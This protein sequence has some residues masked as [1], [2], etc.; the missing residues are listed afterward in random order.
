MQQAAGTRY[1]HL[2]SPLRLGKLALPDRFA[3][4]PMTTNY[5]ALDGAVTPELCDYMAARGA[6]GFSLI[7]TENVGVHESGRVMPRM[8]MGDE[9]RHIPGLARLADAIRATG[10]R[11]IA[12]ISHCGRQT[13]SKFTGMPLVAPSAIP[14]PVNREMPRALA[15]DEVVEMERAFVATAGR[16]EAAGFDGIEIHAAHGYLAGSFLSAYSNHRTDEYGGSLDNRM[17]FL[18]NIVDGIRRRSDITLTVRISA[19]EFVDQ[20]NTLEQSRVIARALE[21]HGVSAISVSAGVYES[22]AVLSMV[23]GEP[24]GRWLSL[25]RAI[26]GEVRIPVL[27]VGMIKRAAVAEAAVARGDCAIPLFGRAAIADPELPRKIREGREHE[28]LPCVSCNICLGRSGRP[29]TICPVNPA[30]GRDRSFAQ[31][32]AKAPEKALRI[33]V[34][35]SCL[36]ALTAAWIAARRGHQVAVYE[37]DGAIGG[38]QRWRGEVPGQDDYAMLVAAAERRAKQ[39]GVQF[40]FRAPAAGEFDRLWSVRRY[41]PGGTSS[42][43]CYEVLGGDASLPASSTL[44]IQGGDLA[45]AEAAVKLAQSGRQVSLSTPHA[46]IC[47][48]AH[49]GFRVLHRRLIKDLG[50]Q[51]CTSAAPAGAT[52]DATIIAGPSSAPGRSEMPQP[53]WDYPYAASGQG[54]T[55]IDDAYESGRMTAGVYAAVELAIS[56]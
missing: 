14:C 5:A 34:T 35:G 43:N 29:E 15:I 18:L 16:L 20:G 4:A 13:K 6:G 40:L 52:G 22:F 54:D 7:I 2:C 46:D 21:G 17:R 19:E 42:P 49:P 24:E 23:S 56:T 28:I 12:Q 41:Q 55:S 45:G 36:A 51:V 48:D 47:L 27:G 1:P 33:A 26:A 37:T 32:I 3:M 8:V 10:A 25:S 44:V 38:M 50:G 39:A 30:V 53:H 11:S 31:A 9:D